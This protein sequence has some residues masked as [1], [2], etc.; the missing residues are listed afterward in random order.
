MTARPALGAALMHPVPLVALALLV[1]NDHLLKEWRPGLVTGK[2]SDFAG[3]VL[4]PLVLAAVL[5]AALPLRCLRRGHYPVVSAWA[6]A[7][8]VAV[9]FAATKTW[10]PATQ[11]YEALFAALRAPLRWL[12]AWALGQPPWHERIVLVRDPSDLVAVPMGALAALV[13]IKLARPSSANQA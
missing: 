1:V 7:A 6:C 13:R 12:A 10:S 4:A 2:L 11:A 9:V 3:M 8:A 5:D